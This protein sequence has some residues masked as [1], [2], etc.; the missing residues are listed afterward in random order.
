MASKKKKKRI[1]LKGRNFRLILT[2]IFLF[3]LLSAFGFLVYSL[4][5]QLFT[6]NKHFTLR[7]IIV[8]RGIW[9]KQHIKELSAILKIEKGKTNLL[10]ID[11]EGAREKLLQ[12]PTIEDISVYKLLPDALVLNITERIPRAFLTY[13]NS[14]LQV[15]ANSVIMPTGKSITLSDDLPVITE[16]RTKDLKI[17]SKLL[18]VKGA[19]DFIK[20]INALLKRV[21]IH[22]ISLKDK[23]IFNTIIYDRKA[24]RQYHLLILRDNISESLESLAD[25]LEDIKRGKVK[26][27]ANTINLSYKGLAYVK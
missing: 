16:L 15:D 1:F 26:K 25:L 8:Q 5:K 10:N 12:E 14:D 17:G 24:G 3:G 9:W 13:K 19:L 4:R 20:Q 2:F 22:R 27:G 23:K 21:K 6:E 18:E 7:R 11:Y